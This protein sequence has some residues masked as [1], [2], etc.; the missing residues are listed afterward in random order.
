MDI[1]WIA[2]HAP[3]E[4]NSVLPA[5]KP[6]IG[7]QML[8]VLAMKRIGKLLYLNCLRKKYSGRESM[9]I[10]SKL[11]RNHSGIFSGPPSPD[12]HSI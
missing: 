3:I 12:S 5:E 2:H 1:L 9:L 4:K 7:S 11:R 10:T 8:S 6:G